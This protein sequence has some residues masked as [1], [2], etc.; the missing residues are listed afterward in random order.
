MA[1]QASPQLQFE[2]PTQFAA[3]RRRLESLDPQRLADIVQLLAMTDAG[4]VIK[5]VL[6]A[7]NSDWA[8]QVPAWIA[9]FAVAGSDLVVIF[10][11]RSPSYPHDT[12]DDVLR[13][14]VAHVLIERAAGGRPVPRW[15]NEG[16]AMAVE[17]TWR[18]QDQ[19]QLLYQLMLGSRTSLAG[20]DRLFGGTPS[21]QTRAYALAGSFVRD[22][23][24]ERGAKIP[25][26]ILMRVGRGSSFDDA[27]TAATGKT[28]ATAN[29]E[30][31]ER[32]RIW[33]T[34]VPIVT[35]TATLWLAV[36]VL[37]LFAIRR[38]RQKDA[39]IEEKWEE[40]EKSGPDG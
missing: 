35:S 36:T 9:G 21:D 17:R 12:F 24:Q 10:P 1:M 6:A 18:F 20:L 27:F 16:L 31:W 38:R 14:E 11:E 33:T 19:T 29:S 25:G 2:A 13:H 37:A 30:F 15:F 32:Q 39:E 22:L 40:E 7:E 4:P 8:R 5:V 34:W 28:P 26:G 3:I 23:L